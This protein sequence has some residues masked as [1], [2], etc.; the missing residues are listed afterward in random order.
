VLERTVYF[1]RRA[2]RNMLQSPVLCGAAV[3]T[4]AVALTILAFFAIVVL[5]VQKLT[6]HW[7]EEVQVIAYLDTVPAERELRQWIGDIRSLPEV[8]EVAFVSRQEALKRFKKR[9]ADDADL[10]VGV[11]PAILPASL[12]ISLREGSRNR[13]GVGNVVARLRQ[14]P[15]LSDLR[16]G[17]EWL[18]RFESFLSL[19]RLAGAILGGFLLFSALFIVAN[20]IK[21]TLYARR[22]ELEVMALVGATPA[23]IKSPFLLEGAVQGALGGVLAVGGAYAL[24][25]LF[26]QQGLNSL[27]LASGSVQI[28][29]LPWTWQLL[30]VTSGILLGLTGSLL[31]L[32]KF[33]RI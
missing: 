28:T 16:Y 9:L 21:L 18:E 33:V 12:E 27:L 17:Q 4:V 15:A 23:F 19:L 2:V 22:D 13:Q 30:M 7:G 20:T 8:G 24:F 6:R 11:D 29:F 31:S 26:L 10:L 1:V 25:L 32:R 3:A 14:N 5:N